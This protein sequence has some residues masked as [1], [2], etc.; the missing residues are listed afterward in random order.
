MNDV[1]KDVAQSITKSLQTPA[2]QYE[3][4]FGKKPH[5]RMLPESILAA[6]KE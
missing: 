1:I 3:A 4:K 5:H 6:L 2:Q